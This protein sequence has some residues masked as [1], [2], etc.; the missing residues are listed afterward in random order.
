MSKIFARYPWIFVLILLLV[1][2]WTTFGWELDSATFIAHESSVLRLPLLSCWKNLPLIFSRDFLVFTDGQFRPL[3]YAVL[4]VVRTFV[5]SDNVLFWHLWLLVFHLINAFLLFF[6]VRHF[7]NHPGSAVFTALIFGLHPL[8]SVVV[9]NINY[10][11]YVFGLSFYLGALCCYLLFALSLRRWSYIVAVVLFTLGLLTSKVLLTLPI[12]LVAYEVLYRRSGFRLA[13]LRLLPFVAF[14]LILS[15]LWLFYKPHPLYYKYIEFPAGAGWYS[16]FSVVGATGWYI[17]GLLL[18]Q[19]IPVVL[20][21]VVARIYGIM[22][23][24]FLVWGLIDLGILIGAGWALLKKRWVGLGVVLGVAAMFPFVSTAW[25][26]VED[27][28]SWTY[29]Y[30]PLAGLALLVGGLADA[31]WPSGWRSLRAGI[32]GVLS[33]IV[34]SYGVQQVRLNVAS[35]SAVGYWERVLRLNPNSETA[36]VELGKAY[37]DQGEM[38]QALRFLFSPAVKQIQISSLAMARY[39]CD[40]GDYFAAA[41]HLGMVDQEE[42]GLQF[43]RYQTAAAELFY[44]AG[45]IDH[46]EAALGITLMANPHNIVAMVRLAEVWIL[47]GYTPAAERLISR[48]LRIAPSDFKVGRIWTL[49]ETGRRAFVTPETPRVVNPPDPGWLKYTLQRMR[50]AQLRKEII[51]LGE[52]HQRDPVIQMEAAICLLRDGH[53]DRALSKLDSVTQT[54]SSYA[55]AWAAKCWA[56]LE[57]GAYSRAEE[58]GRRAL[59]LDPQSPAAHSALG[60]L[61]R[62][63]ADDPQD[64]EPARQRKLDRAIQYYQQALQLDPRYAAAHNSLGNL[65]A[66]QDRPDEAIEHYRQALRI[67]PDYAEAHNNLGLTLAGQGKPDEAIEHYR[68]ALRIRPDFVEAHTNLGVIL[69]QQDNPKQAIDHFRQALRNRPDYAEAHSNL[70]AVLVQQG[71]SQEGIEHFQQAL[72]SKPDCAKARHNLV[73]VLIRQR[74]FGEALSLVWQLATCSDPNLRNGFEAVR[75][76]KQICQAMEYKHPQALDVLAAA[77]AETGHFDEAIHAAQQAIQ[78]AVRAGHTGLARQIDARLKLYKTHRPYH[79]QP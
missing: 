33:L 44:A 45:A 47:K 36:S 63:L 72:R 22:D 52:H 78:F 67:R 73:M 55:Y 41:I 40:Q 24:K 53:P 27:Y 6:I 68:Q 50:D 71:K 7:V 74:R 10:F 18:G 39:Y 25:N 23:W 51:Q 26:G 69:F 17:K 79:R 32:L 59:Q 70:G 34:L 1:S 75:L 48:A 13:L 62:T 54:L 19:D 11:H 56:A 8:A 61:F 38:P 5:S 20:R 31:L 49:M 77:Y 66:D 37:L 3:S 76:A 14:P 65:L 21:E 58:A 30:V 2:L 28:V 43:Q 16:F 15:P 29:L 46:A 4:A 42:V 57:G 9:N 60:M 35:R 64:S 12:V